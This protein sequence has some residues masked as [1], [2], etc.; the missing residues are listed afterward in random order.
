M[1]INYDQYRGLLT[2]GPVNDKETLYHY[3]VN[4]G[5]DMIILDEA[6]RIKNSSSILS[7]YVKK[8]R[9]RSRL[10]LTGYPLQNRLLEY[11]YMID[12]IAPGLLGSKDAFNTYFSNYIDKCYSDS[13][14]TIKEQATFKLYVLQ[15]LTAHVTHR[16]DEEILIK[17]LPSKTDYVVWFKLS[18]VQRK[19]Y[20]FLLKLVCS[21]SPMISLCI[22]RS[23]CNHPKIFQ[24][25]GLIFF[26]SVLLF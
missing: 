18:P 12:F 15:L 16:R 11:Y 10:C 5:P 1:L 25:V 24:T 9:T 14:K 8:I 3:L 20:M 23:I 19:G 6:H 4:P 22:L 21:D 26:Y 2:T 13:S 17:D 7:A